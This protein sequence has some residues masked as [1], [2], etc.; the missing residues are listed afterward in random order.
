EVGAVLRVPAAASSLT[1]LDTDAGDSPVSPASSTCVSE[2]CCC[3]A[4][5]MRA[6]LASRS[7]PCEPGV[8]RC[9]LTIVRVSRCQTARVQQNKHLNSRSRFDQ[10]CVHF[11]TPRVAEGLNGTAGKDALELLRCRADA[12]PGVLATEAYT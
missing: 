1:M 6:R 9:V 7:E 10:P 2:P 3:T 4:L 11:L 8:T 5:T 12:T